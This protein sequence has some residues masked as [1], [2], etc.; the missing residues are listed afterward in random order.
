MESLK[1]LLSKNS[2][3]HLIIENEVRQT[4]FGTITFTCQIV[5]GVVQI[6][7]LNIVKNKRR[8]Y[9]G[10]DKQDQA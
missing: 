9:Q 4:P 7:T 10:V 8:R 1:H 5:D 2:S 6:E 3:L